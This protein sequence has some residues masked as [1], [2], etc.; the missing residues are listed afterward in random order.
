[1]ACVTACPSGVQYGPLI[2]THARA[3]RAPPSRAPLGD[4]LFRRA[5]VRAAAVSRRACACCALPLVVC[6]PASCARSR[7]SGARASLPARIRSLMRARAAGR[8]G[9]AD[10]ERARAHAGRRA[11]RGCSVG[12]LTG[13]VQ[14][15][16]FAHV[17]QATIDV[18]AA[19]G[20]DV[21]RAARAG[22]LRRAGAACRAAS[23][24]RATFAR[25]NI[26]VFE[27]VRRRSRS[28]STP[29]AADRR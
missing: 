27:R 8:R 14:R 28:S 20:C 2:E 7:A 12:L 17:N 25:S 26:E 13:C 1:M 16:A 5:A 19:E 23:T 21:L 9:V 10:G 29:P 18:L 15:L 4:R 11:R 24:R 22:M 3:D 6:R